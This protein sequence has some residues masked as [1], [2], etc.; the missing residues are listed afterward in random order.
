MEKPGLYVISHYNPIPPAFYRL[1]TSGSLETGVMSLS[2][3]LGR[4][5]NAYLPLSKA[6]SLVAGFN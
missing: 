1:K 4:S 3:S 5:L 6:G 2:L